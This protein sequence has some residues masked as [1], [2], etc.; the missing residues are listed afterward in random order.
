MKNRATEFTFV[1]LREEGKE[2]EKN[3]SLETTAI[4]ALQT[5][6]IEVILPAPKRNS[7]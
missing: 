1:A 6:F 5:H 7:L 3:A 4:L 2:G